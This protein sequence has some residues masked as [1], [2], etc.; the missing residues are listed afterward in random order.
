MADGSN[1]RRPRVIDLNAL[2]ASD[3]AQNPLTEKYAYGAAPVVPPQPLTTEEIERLARRRAELAA[4]QKAKA[5][6]EV[7][8]ALQRRA[9]HIVNECAPTEDEDEE[10]VLQKLANL[11]NK[12]KKVQDVFE[13]RAEGQ[14][15]GYQSWLSAERYKKEEA[16]RVVDAELRKQQLTKAKI[17]EEQIW[18]RDLQALIE[19]IVDSIH[20][21]YLQTLEERER[22]RVADLDS[23]LQAEAAARILAREESEVAKQ[24]ERE[25]FEAALFGSSDP[26]ISDI[27]KGAH[28]R[29]LAFQQREAEAAAAEELALEAKLVR[30]TSLRKV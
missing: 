20:D 15:D 3:T 18:F 30:L 25:A 24:K 12:L 28:E 26:L 17:E 27:R 16:Q 19:G 2:L 13:R 9:E 7:A 4:E 5:D 29:A 11:E 1:I 22:Q 8:A 10:K 21:R 6:A 14:E 23:A